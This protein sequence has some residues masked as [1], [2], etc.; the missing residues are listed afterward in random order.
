MSMANYTKTG[1]I[2]E[3]QYID[4]ASEE[5]K[6]ANEKYEGQE[7]GEVEKAVMTE[8]KKIRSES[9]ENYLRCGILQGSRKDR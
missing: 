9:D 3:E 4:T 6:K 1:E 8:E 2:T 7:K 5:L